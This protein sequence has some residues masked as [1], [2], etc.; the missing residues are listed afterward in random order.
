MLWSGVIMVEADAPD[1]SR[2]DNELIRFR[3]TAG[4][5]DAVRGAR[6]VNVSAVID[7]RGRDLV[8]VAADHV[9]VADTPLVLEKVP[10][11]PAL[12]ALCLYA[13]AACMYRLVPLGAR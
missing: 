1:L 4:L 7:A 3:W 10:P 8:V 11:K 5:A 2:E 13:S 6:G 12:L 9:L